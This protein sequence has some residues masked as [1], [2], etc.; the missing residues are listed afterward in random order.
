MRLEAVYRERL[1]MIKGYEYLPV[2]C[3]LIPVHIIYGAQPDYVH[4]PCHVLGL[5]LLTQ[6]FV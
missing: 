1:A 2:L 6:V 3:K 4:V 5:T